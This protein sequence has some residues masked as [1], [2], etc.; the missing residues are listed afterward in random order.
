MRQAHD[1]EHARPRGFPPGPALKPDGDTALLP[2]LA[3]GSRV[4]PVSGQAR[5]IAAASGPLRPSAIS[6]ITRWPSLS[7]VS[8]A[9]CSAEACTNT[10]LPPPSRTIKP[11]PFIALYHLTV[12]LSCEVTSSGGRSPPPG[13]PPGR[14]P[15]PAPVRGG[16]GAGAAA[17]LVST[18]NTSVTCGPR[19]PCATRTWSVSPGWIS[20]TPPRP[21]TVACRNASPEPSE[22]S[23][24][25]KPFSDL[26]HF[27]TAL[28]TGPEGSSNRGRLKRGAA[29][30]SRGGGS[31]SWSSKLRRRR[32]RKFLS[33][34]N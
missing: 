23:T 11:N 15:P 18:L 1:R 2:D 9:R 6:T 21:S 13:P 27:T 34:S 17:V 12:P 33:F 4:R 16:H 31:N 19:C 22:S 24:N 14:K 29:P 32:C 5:R 25:P 20:V 7:P 26:N 3:S 28:T 30:K 8:P 10:S